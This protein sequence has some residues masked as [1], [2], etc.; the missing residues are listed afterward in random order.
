M[1]YI[2]EDIVRELLNYFKHLF[3]C[4]REILFYFFK[5]LIEIAIMK[6]IKIF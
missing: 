3:Q 2:E 1:Q 5:R 6:Y 4:T